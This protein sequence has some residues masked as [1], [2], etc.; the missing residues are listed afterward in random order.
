VKDVNYY[1]IIIQEYFQARV[2]DFLGNY[3]K[4]LFGIQNYLARFEFSKSLGQ[5][6][7]H[8]LEMLGK[9]SRIT[10]L[11]DL[12]YVEI[13]DMKKQVRITDYWMTTVC[14]LTFP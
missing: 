11:N 9:K 6:N 3:A 5:I 7:V 8:H 13:N 12:V 1:S 4:E 10:E 14:G 2:M